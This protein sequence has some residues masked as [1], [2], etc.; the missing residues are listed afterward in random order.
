MAPKPETEFWATRLT[1]YLAWASGALLLLGCAGMI[2]LDVVTRA[3]FGR[4]V[5]ESFE[6]SSYAF[7]AAV[8]IGLAYTIASKSNI[9]IDLLTTRLPRP[10][11]I[12]LDCLSHLGIVAIALALAWFA[13]ATWDQSRALNARSIS[14]LQVPLV[15]P[16]GVWLA[17]LIWFALFACIV[18]LRVVALLARR[19][20]N[21]VEQLIGPVTLSEEIEQAGVPTTGDTAAPSSSTQPGA[22][23]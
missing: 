19:R 1:R 23:P 18:A 4:T 6:L 5:I 14:T 9:R 3:I 7:A 11:R 15:F 8:T 2:T 16:Q 10:L 17:G 13:F 12:A 22:K 20:Y 21:A